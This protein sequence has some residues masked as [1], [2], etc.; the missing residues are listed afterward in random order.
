MLSFLTDT[1]RL[2]R[3]ARRRRAAAFRPGTRANHDSHALLY[4]AFCIYFQRPDFPA[5]VDGLLTFAE[6]LLRSFQAAKSVTNCLSSLKTFHL[7]HAFPTTAFEHPQLGLWKRALPLTL[8]H[9][10]APAP[11]MSFLLLDKLCARAAR[12]GPRGRSFAAL[13][14]TAFYSLARLSSLVPTTAGPVDASRVP[15]LGD[16]TWRGNGVDLLIK[17]GKAAQDSKDGFWVPLKAVPRS[18]ACPVALLRDLVRLNASLS[19]DAPLFS[20]P[21][22]PAG[23]AAGF[24]TEGSARG[25]LR[26]LLAGEGMSPDGYTFHSLRRGGCSLAFEAGAALPDLQHL[27]G[28]RSRAIDAYYPHHLARARAARVLARESARQLTS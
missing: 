6:F 8:R 3:A 16:L 19:R 5:T 4:I 20:F 11:P 7:C 28:W 14:A 13:L 22:G 24:F 18:S 10:P 27:G 9:C 23:E 25:F 12:G 15:L 17:W 21:Q 26:N 2:Q 1:W